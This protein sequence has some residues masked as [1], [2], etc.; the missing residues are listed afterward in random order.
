[1]TAREVVSSPAIRKPAMCAVHIVR[2]AANSV[3]AIG[4][5]MHRTEH[6]R[7]FSR[8]G[9]RIPAKDSISMILPRM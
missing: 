9:S 8:S 2:A 3:L 6:I 5:R 1:M 4:S 7:I